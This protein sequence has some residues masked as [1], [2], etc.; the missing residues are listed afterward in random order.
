ML[1]ILQRR[2]F[3]H[4]L[5]RLIPLTDEEVACVFQIFDDDSNGTVSVDAPPQYGLK[6]GSRYIVVNGKS[7]LDAAG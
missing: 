2:E 5:R 6:P 4:A 7:L 1:L 3:T